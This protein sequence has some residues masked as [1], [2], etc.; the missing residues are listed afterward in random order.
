MASDKRDK[1][2]YARMKLRE[3]Y[4]R[5]MSGHYPL[6]VAP[7]KYSTEAREFFGYE[8]V[9]VRTDFDYTYTK[10]HNV[11]YAA[12][13]TYET[14]AKINY[15]DKVEVTTTASTKEYDYPVE[16]EYEGVGVVSTIIACK[17][18]TPGKLNETKILEEELYQHQNFK[19]FMRSHGQ[20][21]RPPFILYLLNFLFDIVISPFLLAAFLLT[22]FIPLIISLANELLELNLALPYNLDSAIFDNFYILLIICVVLIVFTVI[23]RKIKDVLDVDHNEYGAVIFAIVVYILT[24]SFGYLDSSI[25]VVHDYFEEHDIFFQVLSFSIFVLSCIGFYHVGRYA[26]FSL[27]RTRYFTA[28]YKYRNN[29][30]G[31]AMAQTGIFNLMQTKYETIKN[32][33]IPM[34]QIDFS[35]LD[36]YGIRY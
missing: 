1:A 11:T 5:V 25:P 32:A 28:L 12:E 10:K 17:F 6:L 14:E 23:N 26:F 24:F 15:Q 4:E 3:T 22:L 2:Y 9:E 19:H 31:K 30:K 16:F 20:H 7:D 35:W 33:I 36:D 21:K 18:L 13:T 27:F 8:L 29:I 34:A